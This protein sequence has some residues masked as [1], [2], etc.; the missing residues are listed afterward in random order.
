M[1]LTLRAGVPWP[2]HAVRRVAAFASAPIG[3][4]GSDRPGIMEM[5]DLSRRE[6]RDRGEK[7]LLAHPAVTSAPGGCVA[8]QGRRVRVFRLVR[9]AALDPAAVKTVNYL[10][11]GVA[12]R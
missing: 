1:A 12:S 11:N 6:S 7:A 5:S 2:R 4:R 10:G 9:E 8:R 3:G